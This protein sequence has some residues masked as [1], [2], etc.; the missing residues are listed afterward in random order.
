MPRGRWNRRPSDQVELCEIPAPPFREFARAASMKARFAAAGLR[1]F[2]IDKAGN[3]IGERAGSV[4]RP[5]LV[6]AAHLDTVFPEGTPIRTT[7]SG[8]VI[9]GPGIGDNC[10]GLAVLL[11]VARSLDRGRVMTEGPITFVANV[12]EDGLGD[13]RGVKY[14]FSEATKGR[15]DRFV[16]ID[17]AGY[18]ITNVAVGSHRYRVTFKGPGGH[19]FGAFGLV[20]PIHALGR[21]VARIAD[22]RVPASPKVTFNVGRI[23][24]GT[25]V[26]SIAHEAWLEMDMRSSDNA[27]L[28]DLDAE[29]NRAIDRATAERTPG[30]AGAPSP[31]RKN[32][33]EIGRRGTRPSKPPSSGA[34]SR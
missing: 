14:L 17:G 28:E 30:G 15:I 32:G 8:A 13:L 19:S 1:D 34:R 6:L 18:G 12:G 16:S 21:A 10:R 23:G 29:F 3:V 9:R 25:S 7:K 20:N 27:A 33:L 11:A 26:N 31:P 5:H 24:G 4:G 2:R 22:F